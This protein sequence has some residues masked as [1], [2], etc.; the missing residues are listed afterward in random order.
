MHL[1]K[2]LFAKNTTIDGNSG[3]ILPLPIDG[4]QKGRSEGK[5]NKEQD[6]SNLLHHATQ[7]IDTKKNISK[8][9]RRFKLLYECG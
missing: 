2:P 9:T 7:L 1:P 5:N 3:F 4:S 8:E 6:Y